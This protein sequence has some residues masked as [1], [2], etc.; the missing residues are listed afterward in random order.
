MSESTTKKWSAA[1]LSAYELKANQSS[2]ILING[3]F[4][5]KIGLP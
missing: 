3:I 2:S 4:K 5:E 1:V